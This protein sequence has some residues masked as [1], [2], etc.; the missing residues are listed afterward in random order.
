MI[1]HAA[2]F[3]AGAWLA[4]LAVTSVVARPWWP[5]AA[6]PWLSGTA[7]CPLAPGAGR[8]ERPAVVSLLAGRLAR[9]GYPATLLDLAARGW[10]SLAEAEPG[11]LMCALPARPP[12]GE[13]TA[14]EQRALAHAALRAQ[15][16]GTAPAAALGSGF[17]IGDPEFAEQFAADVQA[18]V[19]ALGL[20]T[21]RISRA[22]CTLLALWLAGALALGIAAL[23]VSSYAGWIVAVVLGYVGGLR[24][25]AMLYA[26]TRLT[27]AGRAARAHWRDY[28]AVLP[29]AQPWQA[30]GGDRAVAFAAALGEAPEAIAVFAPSGRLLWSAYTGSWRQ[31]RVGDPAEQYAPGPGAL[32]GVTALLAL[33]AAAA[34]V[35]TGQ[36]GLKWGAAFTVFPGC[37]WWG[38]CWYVYFRAAAARRLPPEAEFDGLVLRR[39]TYVESGDENSADVTHY[40]VAIDDG[41]RDQAWALSI[42]RPAYG[43]ARAGMIVH[44]R[45]DPRRNRLLDLS[46]ARP[47]PGAAEL[48]GPDAPPGGPP[49]PASPGGDGSTAGR[50]VP[51]PPPTRPAAGGSAATG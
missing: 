36:W 51:S 24:L 15:L 50:P 44:A 45:V 29:G 7:S 46:P 10:L 4:L 1:A 21:R 42:G 19:T 25:L 38:S 28:R 32:A 27:G 5:A 33:F 13:L 47:V 8:P 26:G 41:Q 17:E 12:A 31:V 22:S 37:I 23:A 11:Q 2:E 20:L 48:P 30:A 35:I 9:T 43:G 6:R 3:A 16:T 34:L 39:W 14:Y 18:E 40:C 49:D